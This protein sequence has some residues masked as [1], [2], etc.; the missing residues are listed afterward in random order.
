MTRCLKYVDDTSY[1]EAAKYIS[2][3]GEN[4]FFFASLDTK[5]KEW[6]IYYK[7]NDDQQIFNQDDFTANSFLIVDEGANSQA[8]EGK[9]HYFVIG[10]TEMKEF[11]CE[12]GYEST[13]AFISGNAKYI[14]TTYGH[15]M[16]EAEI[17]LYDTS[18]GEVL[19]SEKMDHNVQTAYIDEESRKLY[20]AGRGNFIVK[21]F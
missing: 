11:I 18:T 9:L 16:N 21:D 14:L 10:D 13:N 17:K 6:T 15:S 2:G 19:I 5:T 1:G 8:T 4:E 7:L 20:I 12:E 3:T